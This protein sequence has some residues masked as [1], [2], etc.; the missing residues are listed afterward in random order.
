MV[1][2]TLNH[3]VNVEVLQ[4]IQDRFAAAVGLAVII[5]N[6]HGEPITTP[7][8]FTNFC[9]KLRSSKEGLQC[10]VFQTET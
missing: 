8:N 7:S 2:Y 6:E 1:T 10:C 9:S 5:A 3:L 4:E